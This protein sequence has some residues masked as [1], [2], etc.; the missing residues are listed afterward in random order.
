MKSV[1][2]EVGRRPIVA[3]VDRF[4]SG[5]VL[6]FEFMNAAFTKI[7]KG[8]EL[9]ALGAI[10]YLSVRKILF[11]PVCLSYFSTGSPEL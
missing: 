5:L 4:R 2:G 3:E 7:S 8:L 6:R 1:N 11:D 10:I 9:W